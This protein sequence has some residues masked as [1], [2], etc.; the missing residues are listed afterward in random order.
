MLYFIP[1]QAS[2]MFSFREGEGIY[3]IRVF[4]CG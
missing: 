4:K 2:F 3:P 1:K